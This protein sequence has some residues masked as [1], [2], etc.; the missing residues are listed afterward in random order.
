M[1]NMHQTKVKE[2]ESFIAREARER[3]GKAPDMV[4]VTFEGEMINISIA[5]LLTK[6]EKHYIEH[7]GDR[8]IRDISSLRRK[9]FEANTEF[10]ID[11][12][13]RI[14]N[15]QLYFE[16]DDWD[17]RNDRLNIQARLSD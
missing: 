5:G 12:L 11:N 17:L 6:I 8:A 13:S 9:A 10:W 1:S 7:L 16:Y 3:T 14:I 2:M 4:R 15:C